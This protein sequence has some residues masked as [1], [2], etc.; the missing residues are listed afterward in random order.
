MFGGE[1]CDY[2]CLCTREPIYQY[3]TV[4]EVSISKWA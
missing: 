4:F 1:V 3:V 2:V